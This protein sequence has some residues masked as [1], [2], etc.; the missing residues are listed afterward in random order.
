[1]RVISKSVLLLASA[2]FIGIGCA[3][4][5]DSCVADVKW[6]PGIQIHDQVD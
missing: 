1:M 4:A 3:S 6:H 2:F 5:A